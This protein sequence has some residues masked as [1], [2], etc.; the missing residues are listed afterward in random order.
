MA[1]F[2]DKPDSG[3]DRKTKRKDRNGRDKLLGCNLRWD[4]VGRPPNYNGFLLSRRTGR[5]QR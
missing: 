4:N 1:L 2:G 5:L 3:R